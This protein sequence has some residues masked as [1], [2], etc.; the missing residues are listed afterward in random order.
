[1]KSRLT[2]V[3]N[4]E[5]YLMGGHGQGT[6]ICLQ[7]LIGII[8]LSDRRRGALLLRRNKRFLKHIVTGN[9]SVALLLT[10]F[11]LTLGATNEWFTKRRAESAVQEGDGVSTKPILL[12]NL[13]AAF[14]I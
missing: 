5:F 10:I 7:R 2:F 14:A 4:Q 12:L 11:V 3:R 1:M 8:F 6:A 9:N 13:A